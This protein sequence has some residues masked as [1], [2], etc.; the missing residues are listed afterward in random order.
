[1]KDLRRY[2]DELINKC[3]TCGF[4]YEF[5]PVYDAIGSGTQNN[6]FGKGSAHDKLSFFQV[7]NI[8]SSCLQCRACYPSCFNGITTAEMAL[9]GRAARVAEN[10]QC[11]LKAI[12]FNFILPN[13]KRID[14]LVRAFSLVRRMGG[15]AL[16][17]R[18]KILNNK[19]RIADSLIDHELNIVSNGTLSRRHAQNACASSVAYFRS[20]G[21]SRVLPVVSD[22]TIRLVENM[23]YKIAVPDNA[24]CGLPP[25]AHGDMNAARNM[26][27][28]NI[29]T[30]GKYETI[31]T[32]CGSCSSFLKKYAEL[33]S[34]DSEYAEKAGK[35]SER[36]KDTNEFIAKGV[37]GIAQR[38][39]HG[40]LAFRKVTYHDA[41]HLSRYQG[42]TEEPR[43][44]IKSIPG[45]DFVEL[46]ESDKCC[47]GAGVYSITNNDI[48]MRILDR[49]IDN[50]KKTGA[51]II[52]TSCPACMVQL[53]YGAKRAGLNTTVMHINQLIADSLFGK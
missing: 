30:L 27:K 47:G 45:L 40:D 21:F 51:S 50:L 18:F 1:M 38:F 42:I 7:D 36:I 20:C 13:P 11:R 52:A 17:K 49:K 9:H 46:P 4:C 2:R 41:C 32:E 8:L 28:K 53:S 43:E 48:S 29:D 35:L 25:Y 37:S 14:F 34:D 26:A 22:T 3:S 24:C 12:I 23:G 5:C 39:V 31:L 15:I 6:T 16:A 10:G 44:I 33:L 19:L